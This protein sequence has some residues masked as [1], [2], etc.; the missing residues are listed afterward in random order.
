VNSIPPCISDSDGPGPEIHVLTTAI[1]Q[2]LTLAY[3][4]FRLPGPS[5]CMVYYRK[6]ATKLP[7]HRRLPSG[8]PPDVCVRHA[9]NV[10]YSPRLP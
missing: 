2:L 8:N 1:L 7:S 3:S 10:Q 4:I 6:Y 9:F 5:K